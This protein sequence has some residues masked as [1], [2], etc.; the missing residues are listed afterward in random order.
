MEIDWWNRRLED[1]GIG[2]IEFCILE[3]VWDLVDTPFKSDISRRS[4]L[5][6]LNFTF[7][8]IKNGPF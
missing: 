2:G 4:I 8:K 3:F 6:T 7:S 5:S 1:W